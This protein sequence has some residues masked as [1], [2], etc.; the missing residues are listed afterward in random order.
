MISSLVSVKYFN[1]ISLR[2]RSS[3]NDMKRTLKI[4][5]RLSGDTGA[6]AMTKE[7]IPDKLMQ[8]PS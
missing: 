3:S 2:T 4:L 5:L 1:R 8:G 7:G 6:T